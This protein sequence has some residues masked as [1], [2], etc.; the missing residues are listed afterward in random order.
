MF[1]LKAI[2]KNELSDY[3]A[4][5]EIEHIWNEAKHFKYPLET[6]EAIDDCIERLLEY[7][8]YQYIFGRSYF[9]NFE[10]TVTNDVLIPRPETEE[11]LHLIAHEWD[12]FTPKIIDIGTGSGCLALGLAMLIKGANVTALDVSPKALAVAYQNAIDLKVK[13]E[14]IERDILVE[15]LD[16][17][18]EVIVSNPPYI[19]YSEKKL[20]EENVLQYEP[21]L[22]LF[23]D[24][25]EALI[26]YERIA[27]L[28]KKHLKEGGNLYF[29]CNEFSAREVAGLCEAKGYKHCEVIKDM[30]GKDRIVKAVNF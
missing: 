22:A 17:Q 2:F 30:Q 25:D 10:L 23:V 7:E 5:S 24:N 29:E 4:E 8:P 27:N 1:D 20:M 16:E 14:F 3:F 19:P 18:Y 11:L 6:K 28:G 15:G 12:G 13:L 9:Y 21:E 26:F